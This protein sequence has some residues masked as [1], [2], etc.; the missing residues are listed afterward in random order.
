MIILPSVMTGD[1]EF[2]G[3]DLI[4]TLAEQ[5]VQLVAPY[6]KRNAKEPLQIKYRA[7]LY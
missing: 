4:E 3:T 6:N 5:N 2:D 1:P 7:E